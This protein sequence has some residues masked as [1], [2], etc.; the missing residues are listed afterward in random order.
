MWAFE[1]RIA[2]NYGFDPAWVGGVLGS[3]LIFA[4]IGPL[5]SGAVGQKFGNRVPFLVACAFTV[6]GIVAIAGSSHVA[7]YYAL[8]ACAFMFGW[9]GGMPFIYSKVAMEDPDGRHLALTIPAIGIG[10]M[11][12]PGITGMFYGD[13]SIVVLQWMSVITVALAAALIWFA[14]PQLSPDPSRA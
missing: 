1:E 11:L 6:A 13:G 10:S 14:H 3:S 8:G 4:V 2:T 12:G 7:F 9:G 5:V